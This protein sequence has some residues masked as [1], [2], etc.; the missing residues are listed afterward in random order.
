MKRKK[1]MSGE[2]KSKKVATKIIADSTEIAKTMSLMIYG[3]GRTMTV[4]NLKPKQAAAHLMQARD[5]MVT[6]GDQMFHLAERILAWDE[7]RIIVQG[8]SLVDVND[9]PLIQDS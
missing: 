8:K 2:E 3:L 5:E 9:R 6:L 7:S 1:K 4:L